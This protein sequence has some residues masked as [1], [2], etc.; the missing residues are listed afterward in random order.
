MSL[1]SQVTAFHRN[2]KNCIL[3]LVNDEYMVI[4]IIIVIIIIEE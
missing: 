2:F 3:K 1:T 4:L